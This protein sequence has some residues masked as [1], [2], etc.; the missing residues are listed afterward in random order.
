MAR[1]ELTVYVLTRTGLSTAAGSFTA[2]V[3]DGHKFINDGNVNIVL[4]N[5]SGSSVTVTLQTP[6][7]VDGNAIANLAITLAA[8]ARLVAGSFPRSVYNQSDGRVYVDYSA[9]SGVTIMAIRTPREV[10]P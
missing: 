10:L 4:A 5:S 7:T 9:T 6:G 1:A 8:G 3:A 2:A